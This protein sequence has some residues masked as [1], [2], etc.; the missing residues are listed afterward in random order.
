[1]SVCGMRR[2]ISAR[3]NTMVL[4]DYLNI[5]LCQVKVTKHNIIQNCWHELFGRM[6]HSFIPDGA[7]N[8][9][10]LWVIL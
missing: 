8:T 3:K 7:L 2:K 6:M 5:C 4:T 10:I 1:M 9:G